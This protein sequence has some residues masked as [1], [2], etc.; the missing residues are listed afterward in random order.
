MERLGVED[1]DR[2]FQIGDESDDEQGPPPPPYNDSTKIEVDVDKEALP[3][4]VAQ[5]L[6]TDGVQEQGSGLTHVQAANEEM[7]A[8]ETARRK[9]TVQKGD[10]I[11]SL[12][13]KYKTD[14]SLGHHIMMV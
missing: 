11:R 9:H 2:S 1:L 6:R 4:N 14:V 7:N 13:L 3:Q 12:A 10:T 5:N 8:P